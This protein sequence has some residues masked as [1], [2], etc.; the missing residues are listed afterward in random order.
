M[1]GRRDNK[2]VVNKSRMG[3]TEELK[4]GGSGMKGRQN[5]QSTAHIT[6]DVISGSDPE[7]RSSYYCARPQRS[8]G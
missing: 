6:E 1:V 8:E 5:L 4:G 2:N 3:R 7:N